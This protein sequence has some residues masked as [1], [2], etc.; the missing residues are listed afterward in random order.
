[1]GKDGQYKIADFGLAKEIGQHHRQ[2]N[3]IVGTVTYMSPELFKGAHYNS[4]TDI[5][6]FGVILLEM[7]SLQVAKKDLKYEVQ[8]NRL[9]VQQWIEQ[10][11]KRRYSAKVLY[12]LH[13]CLLLEP[14]ARLTAEQILIVLD[15][16]HAAEAEDLYRRS[17]EYNRED[18]KDEHDG[19]VDHSAKSSVENESKPK[20]RESKLTRVFTARAGN[21]RQHMFKKEQQR[22]QHQQQQQEQQFANQIRRS[23]S[24]SNAS[25]WQRDTTIYGHDHMFLFRVVRHDTDSTTV[26]SGVD[27]AIEHPGDDNLILRRSSLDALRMTR[28]N[29]VSDIV[30][31]LLAC[32]EAIVAP[33]FS[34]ETAGGDSDDEITFDMSESDDDDDD[35]ELTTAR[36]HQEALLMTLNYFCRPEEVLQKIIN[37][38]QDTSDTDVTIRALRTL[39]TWT[40][41]G[42]LC[43]FN[44]VT[45]SLLVTFCFN[46][47][48]A[49]DGASAGQ[50]NSGRRYRRVKNMS[51]GVSPR[52]S[53]SSS[54]SPQRSG[55][56]SYVTRG[57]SGY[58]LNSEIAEHSHDQKLELISLLKAELAKQL[59]RHRNSTNSTRQSAGSTHLRMNAPDPIMPKISQNLRLIEFSEIEIARQLTLLDFGDFHQVKPFEFM[60]LGL[61]SGTRYHHSPNI[62]R[63]I[64]RFNRMSQWVASCVVQKS[65]INSRALRIVKLINIAEHLHKL[66]NFNTL[67]AVVFGL[68]FTAVSRLSKTWTVVKREHVAAMKMLQQ[69]TALCESNEQMDQCVRNCDE[70]ESPCVPFIGIYLSLIKT[71]EMELPTYQEGKS[72]DLRSTGVTDILNL[73]KFTKIARIIKEIQRLQER[74]YM[75]KRVPILQDKLK[76]IM[77]SAETQQQRFIKRHAGSMSPTLTPVRKT[78]L[79]AGSSSNDG[80]DNVDG[81]VEL[82]YDDK[83]LFERSLELERD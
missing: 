6:S 16:M 39:H 62:L 80:L 82:L 37:L 2:Q 25:D 4:A 76:S 56:L 32:E 30:R 57:D 45:V 28:R 64:N 12:I 3:S 55:T 49:G 81:M 15:K 75:L 43:Q 48:S 59:S 8:T 58:S 60:L 47:N 66:N 13:N 35:D 33:R 51:I 63:M 52:L 40:S 29:I 20:R 70:K 83:A 17:L 79:R 50:M 5:W 71:L 18:E 44:N 65:D 14:D 36:R 72:I 53:S 21:L 34:V 78:T 69:Y 24:R 11:L 26:D 9:F 73:D 7:L 46:D 77:T 41:R 67:K 42:N 23:G 27:I 22:Q 31:F 74:N 19:D 38:C 1:M 54:L 61:E 10:R 68:H